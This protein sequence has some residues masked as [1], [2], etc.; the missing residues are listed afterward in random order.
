LSLSAGK[1]P[2][3]QPASRRRYNQFMPT[4]P[5]VVLS[6]AGYD[7]SSGAGIT[8]DVKTA[9][10]HGCFAVTCITA[11]TIQTTLGVRGVEAVPAAVI[12]RTLEELNSDFDIAAV[13]IGMLG[14]AALTVADFLESAQL[15]NVVLD[16]VIKSSSGADLIDADGL[17]VLRER[18]IP[19]SRVITPN[20][21]EAFALTELR[22]RK[23]AAQEL[24]K[25]G[26]E[27]VVI[28]GGHLDEAVDL[29]FTDGQFEE[30]RGPKIQ[31]NATH[32]TGCAFATS[33]A[34]GLAKGKS[35]REA[36]IQAKEFVRRAI[37]SAHLVG[38]GVGPVNP[39][40]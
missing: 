34:C 7:P 21:D 19:L 8:A 26:A 1:V 23:Q 24:N 35:V 40:F 27:A 32:G 6:I 39:F 5:P 20:V 10:A 13:R 9:A 37:E 16:P 3:R 36:V 38:K 30:F 11:L 4:T 17:R 28:T 33:V 12:R 15:K 29:L 31:S 14:S 22:D 18:L 25:M 2:A